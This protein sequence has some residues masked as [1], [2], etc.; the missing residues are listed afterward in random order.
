LPTNENELLIQA[1]E[2]P[3]IAP[4]G[5]ADAGMHVSDGHR[6]VLKA[7]F[8]KNRH[9]EAGDHLHASPNDFTLEGVERRYVVLRQLLKRNRFG[10]LDHIGCRV[11]AEAAEA[12]V[13]ARRVRAHVAATEAT[14]IGE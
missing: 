12:V 13:T 5:L 7:A 8:R 6:S 9:L 1:I 3:P 10:D 11:R 4:L 14:A 2:R